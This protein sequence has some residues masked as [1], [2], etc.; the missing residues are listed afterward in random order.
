MGQASQRAVTLEAV[1]HAEP[2]VTCH[3]EVIASGVSAAWLA[4]L[5]N[6]TLV[7]PNVGPTSHCACV[8]PG[9]I[10]S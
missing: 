1:I 4:G 5:L 7:D 9:L 6:I 8:G 10:P 3:V 2:S